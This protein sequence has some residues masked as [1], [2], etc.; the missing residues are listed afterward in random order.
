MTYD[1]IDQKRFPLPVGVGGGGRGQE[2]P[3]TSPPSRHAARPVLLPARSRGPTSILACVMQP[4]GRPTQLSCRRC[5]QCVR[6]P[7]KRKAKRRTDREGGRGRE[8]ERERDHR[9]ARVHPPSSG[10]SLAHS[11]HLY[12]QSVSGAT[13]CPGNKVD[14]PRTDARTVSSL[15]S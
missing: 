11:T 8:S 13:S 15:S 7:R 6:E 5:E 12:L 10:H 9:R 14:G 4:T 2:I 1:I 3:R